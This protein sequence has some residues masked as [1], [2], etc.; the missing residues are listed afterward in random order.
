[1]LRAG[2][3]VVD[4]RTH[5]RPHFGQTNGQLKLHLGLVVPSPGPDD[6]GDDGGGGGAPRHCPPTL[7]VAGES[8]SWRAGEVLGFDDSFRHEVW[9]GCAAAAGDG[10]R[11]VFQVVVAHPHLVDVMRAS[12]PRREL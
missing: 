11:A 12:E 6:G 3:S 5:I 4:A 1:M 9:N 2:Y 10:W 8:R 7:R